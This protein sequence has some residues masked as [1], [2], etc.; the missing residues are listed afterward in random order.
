MREIVGIG[1]ACNICAHISVGT[2]RKHARA[3]QLCWLIRRRVVM[4]CLGGERIDRTGYTPREKLMLA[5]DGCCSTR[6][7]WKR[8]RRVHNGHADE[9]TIV[10]YPNWQRRFDAFPQS[11]CLPLVDA[12]H[13]GDL[14]ARFS[15][16]LLPDNPT[17]REVFAQRHQVAGS[18]I[19]GLLAAL[20]E[21]CPGAMQDVRP[22]RSAVVTSGALDGVKRLRPREVRARW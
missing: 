16:A 19:F 13:T 2:T 3:F 11:L 20:E 6:A 12:V 1:C 8:R 17:V 9:T 5:F 10:H 7:T 18:D 22:E 21:E 4:A 15:G 14:L